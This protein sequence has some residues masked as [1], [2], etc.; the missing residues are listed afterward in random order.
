[1]YQEQI[2]DII[3]DYMVLLLQ[4]MPIMEIQMTEISSLF[5][6]KFARREFATVVFQDKF[7]Q[8]EG[9]CLSERSY[10]ELSQIIFFALLNFQNNPL[11]YEDVRLIT[12]STF[13]YYRIVNDK[14]YYM[15]NEVAK[16]DVPFAMW[17]EVD[18]WKCW[19]EQDLVD[20]TRAGTSH[21]E[22]ENI[23]LHT[24]VMVAKKMKDL[25]LEVSFISSCI[26]EKIGKI[27]IQ[28]VRLVRLILRLSCMSS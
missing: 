1:M 18:F 7:R 21:E 5:M 10:K 22:E 8:G 17:K 15:Y 20:M 26:H 13:Y 23:Y 25:R 12:K 3:R 24:L 4:S 2:G 27:Y 16:N 19:V 14:F 6:N 9:H 28:D 11:Q